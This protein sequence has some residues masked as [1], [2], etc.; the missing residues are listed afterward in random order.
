MHHPVHGRRRGS[1]A[2]GVTE[3]PVKLIIQSDMPDPRNIAAAPLS[4]CG[5]VAHHLH[6]R[7]FPHA[8]QPFGYVPTPA[9]V[10]PIEFTHKAGDYA[11]LGGYVDNVRAAEFDHVHRRSRSG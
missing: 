9:L 1:F 5:P 7:R 2:P 11:A 4:T 10:A 3:N 6:G 8:A